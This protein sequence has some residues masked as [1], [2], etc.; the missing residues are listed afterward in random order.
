M[1]EWGEVVAS[2]LWF[3]IWESDE[4]VDEGMDDEGGFGGEVSDWLYS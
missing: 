2:I 4:G 1:R 3:R